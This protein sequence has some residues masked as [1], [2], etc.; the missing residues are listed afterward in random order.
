VSASTYIPLG[1]M[2]LFRFIS[3]FETSLFNFIYLLVRWER[4]MLKNIF[5]NAVSMM[6]FCFGVS[7]AFIFFS[8]YLW[9]R[10]RQKVLL[11]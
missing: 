4:R 10:V 9:S 2:F 11:E 8:A 6:L 5:P 3:P 7:I 1:N